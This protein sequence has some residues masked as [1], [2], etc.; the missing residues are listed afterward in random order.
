[1]TERSNQIQNRP[2]AQ[3]IEDAFAVAAKQA[4]P[5]AYQPKVL[6]GVC[7][8]ESGPLGEPRHAPLAPRQDLEDFRPMAMAARFRYL[9]ELTV[10]GCDRM[11][12]RRQAD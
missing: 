5:P 12:G 1:V 9:S 2:V 7:D 3:P 4:S 8:R 6:R 10:A 11:G